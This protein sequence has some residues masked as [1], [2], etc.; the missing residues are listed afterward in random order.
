MNFLIKV[1]F[2]KV[3]RSD[4]VEKLKNLRPELKRILNWDIHIYCSLYIYSLKKATLEK[5]NASKEELE[6]INSAIGILLYEYNQELRFEE[7][8]IKG[9]SQLIKS[10]GIPN[11][12]SLVKISM[13]IGDAEKIATEVSKKSSLLSSEWIKQLTKDLFHP[14]T[15]FEYLKGSIVDDEEAQ[16]ID[17][18]MDSANKA[19]E[20]E[21]SKESELILSKMAS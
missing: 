10:L 21:L 15:Y 5:S 11:S 7:T 19:L 16:A 20:F 12:I 13:G 8:G 3:I 14:P 2:K 1:I 4:F 9:E 17:L 18:A 6:D